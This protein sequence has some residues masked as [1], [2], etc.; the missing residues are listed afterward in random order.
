MGS[1]EHHLEDF[2][3][4]IVDERIREVMERN[5]PSQQN[6]NHGV[7]GREYKFGKKEAVAMRKM[8]ERGVSKSEI[9]RKFKCCRITV[10]K[11]LYEYNINKLN[12]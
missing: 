1:I 8:H 3:R 11:Y 7:R 6:E 2:V 9:A 4:N 12:K 10:N 5:I